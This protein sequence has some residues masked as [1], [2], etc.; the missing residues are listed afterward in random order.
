MSMRHF[1]EMRQAD[2]SY[3][4]IGFYLLHHAL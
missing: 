3:Q 1:S 4:K 2:F